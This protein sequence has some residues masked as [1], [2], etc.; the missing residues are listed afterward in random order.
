VYKWANEAAAPTQVYSGDG[1]ILG[2]R[3]GDDLAAI[4]SGA[5]T[6]LVAGYGTTPSVTGNNGYAIIDPTAGTATAVGFAGT[7]P[8]AGDFRLGITFTDASHVIGTQGNAVYGYTSFSGSTGTFIGNGTLNTPGGSTAERFVDYT[9]INNIPYLAVQSSGDAHVAVYSIA[10]PLNPI[11]QAYGLATTGTLAANGNATGSIAWG[12]PPTANP[13][14][15]FSQ[16]LYAMRTNAGIQ[17][18]T[19]VIPPPAVPGDYN[20]NGAV[21]AADYVVWR[22]TDGTATPPGS[23]ADGDGSGTV[24]PE[25]FE[26]WRARFGNANPGS[27]TGIGAAVPEPSP[28]LL[29]LILAAVGL[30]RNRSHGRFRN[31]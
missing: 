27:G 9:V 21:D 12:A 18:F 11:F 17:A 16:V 20:G 3:I 25:D 13:D 19:F 28:W 26:F 4:G 15:S 14:G 23:G 10:D 2:V 8:N 1:G 7:P 29:V 5:S 6:L 30:G 24:G 31:A 22:K